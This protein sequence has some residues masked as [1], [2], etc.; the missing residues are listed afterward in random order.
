MSNANIAKALAYFKPYR[1]SIFLSAKTRATK[2][3][4]NT[5]IAYWL[6]TL[7]RTSFVD[8]TE[9]A[10]IG[11]A[12]R[13]RFHSNKGRNSRGKSRKYKNI[14]F[15]ILYVKSMLNTVARPLFPL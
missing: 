6:S 9:I 1:V 12:G 4:T 5:P 15:F 8:K 10:M 14:I 11:T 2:A 3:G 13:K 7:E